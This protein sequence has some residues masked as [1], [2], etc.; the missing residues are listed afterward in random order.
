MNTSQIT[1]NFVNETIIHAYENDL[2]LV[3]NRIYSQSR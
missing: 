1:L 3:N 2:Q